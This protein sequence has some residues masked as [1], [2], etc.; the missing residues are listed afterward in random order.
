MN[1][2]QALQD[3]GETVKPL[4]QAIDEYT[5]LLQNQE[6]QVAY[7]GIL[8]C[9]GMLRADCIRKFPHY[10][11]GSLYQ[12]YM[13]MSYFSI[14]TKLF[15]ARGLKLALVYQHEKGQFE[16]WLSAR[17]RDIAK[18][19]ASESIRKELETLPVF[20]DAD[21]LDAVIECTLAAKPDFED[22]A[23]LSETLCQGAVR[24]M[25]AVSGALIA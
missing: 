14:S 17:N 7:R 3:R 22:Q 20:H 21:N 1:P 23:A 19:F 13:D 25:E 8:E 12:G 9:M 4:N 16:V 2:Y 24:F 18:R 5:R 11:V 10:D 15:R 6:I